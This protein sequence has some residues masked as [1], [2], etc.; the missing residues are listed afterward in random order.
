MRPLLRPI[1]L[2]PIPVIQKVPKLPPE[3]TDA[4]IDTL[5]ICRVWL[6][7]TRYRLFFRVGVRGD[8][9]V[10]DHKYTRLYHFARF[11]LN[12]QHVAPYVRYFCVELLTDMDVSCHLPTIMRLLCN[13]H[14]LSVIPVIPFRADFGTWACLRSL[15]C[16]ELHGTSYHYLNLLRLLDAV[17]HIRALALFGI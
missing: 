13:L 6:P 3:L 11:L 14:S 17:S 5:L 2:V 9:A 8:A 4:I 10:E 16:L 12:S 15:S 1:P 7:R